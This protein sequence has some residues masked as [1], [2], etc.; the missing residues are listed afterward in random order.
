MSS[1]AVRIVRDLPW[2]QPQVGERAVLGVWSQRQALS[3][4]TPLF[5]L[6]EFMPTAIRELSSQLQPLHGAARGP[7]KWVSRKS[8]RDV[9]FVTV[10]RQDASPGMSLT[11]P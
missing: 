11:C 3:S 10:L 4:A 2:W 5:L 6:G 1:N 7:G 8:N 9:S